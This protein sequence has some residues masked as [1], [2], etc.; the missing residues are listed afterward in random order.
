[1]TL[2]E[3]LDLVRQYISDYALNKVFNSTIIRFLN[4]GIKDFCLKTRIYETKITQNSQNGVSD[5][6]LIDTNGK[7]I[8]KVRYV[9]YD[10]KE[11]EPIILNKLFDLDEFKENTEGTPKYYTQFDIK[12]ISLYPI[13]DEDGKTIEIIGA[14]F[15]A[16]NEYFSENNLTATSPL[17]SEWDMALVYYASGNIGATLGDDRAKGYLELYAFE[18][19][20]AIKFARRKIPYVYKFYPEE[21]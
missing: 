20:N 13:P 4:A 7:E 2:S 19:A 14:G 5:Y 3:I 18:L 15:P 16:S 11:L 10:K 6:S 8:F 1:M 9:L 12:A 21:E 17:G